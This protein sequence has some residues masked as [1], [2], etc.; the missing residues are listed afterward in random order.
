MGKVHL[1]RFRFEEEVNIIT[2]NGVRQYLYR[3]AATEVVHQDDMQLSESGA[4][5]IHLVSCVPSLVYD[6]RLIV[7]GELIGVK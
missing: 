2:D 4:A 3:V 5:T 1:Q 6:H 7:T